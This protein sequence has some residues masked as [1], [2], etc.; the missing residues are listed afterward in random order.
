M[1]K[2]SSPHCV[3]EV[4]LSVP[5]G[6]AET[7]WHHV[8]EIAGIKTAEFNSAKVKRKGKGKCLEVKGCV[9]LLITIW[10]RLRSQA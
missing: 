6:C 2:A 5:Y 7:I 3:C 1:E 9:E 4:N 8:Q 10:P